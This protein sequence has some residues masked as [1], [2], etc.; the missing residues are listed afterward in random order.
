MPVDRSSRSNGANRGSCSLTVSR[1]FSTS[2]IV[3]LYLAAAFGLRDLAERAPQRAALGR[4]ACGGRPIRA[5]GATAA[6][7]SFL[8]TLVVGLLV[9]P[10]E[11]LLF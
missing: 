5:L 7:V 8:A 10:G 2:V 11:R 6:L 9:S 1:S 4:L 3:S